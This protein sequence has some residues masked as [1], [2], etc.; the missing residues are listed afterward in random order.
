[1]NKL[2]CPECGSNN[3]ATERKLNGN[4]KCMDC[5]Y[6]WRNTTDPTKPHV[7]VH[8]VAELQDKRQMVH[9]TLTKADGTNHNIWVFVNEDGTAYVDISMP[10]SS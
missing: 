10:Y 4:N 3:I 6:V 5:R 9:M 1:M 7:K 2:T 8:D